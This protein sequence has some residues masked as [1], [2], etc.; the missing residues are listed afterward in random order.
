MTIGTRSRGRVALGVVAAVGL[1]AALVIV[2]IGPATVVES[3][4]AFQAFRRSAEDAVLGAVPWPVVAQPLA[5]WTRG[6]LL[7]PHL[8]IPLGFILLAE[9][10][11]P[12]VKSQRIF[13]VALANDFLWYLAEI[14]VFLFV[15]MW[16]AQ[17]LRDLYQRSFGLATVAS[18][19]PLP[20]WLAFVIAVLIADFIAWGNHYVR[21]K[22]PLFWFFH[23][24]HHSQRELNALT[25]ERVHPVEFIVSLLITFLPATVLGVSVGEMM[26]FV[27]FS[28]WHTRL[29]H[30][31]IRSNY[32]P[33]RFVFVT[34]QSHRVHHSA[35]PEHRDRN[36]GV[37]F[38]LWDHLFGTQCRDYDVYPETGIDDVTFPHERQ[39]QATFSLRPFLAQQ[40]YPLRLVAQR[41]GMLRE[42]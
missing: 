24:V 31:N 5:K 17:G 26:G 10:V 34:P 13:S 19:V 14:G 15:N 25:N 7:A 33:L 36:F 18:V 40:I 8:F 1:L 28:N 32:G 4:Y 22:V 6:V 41:L 30:A 12:A 37:I 38:S 9:W 11:V 16:A 39:W 2:A 20:A 21:H 35:R 27:I 29:Y 42:P 23:T 3:L